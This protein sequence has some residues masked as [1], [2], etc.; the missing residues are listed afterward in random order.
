MSGFSFF[1][2]LVC[3]AI[4]LFF[5][6][7]QYSEWLAAHHG[8]I[9]LLVALF[10]MAA[11]CVL[12]FPGL[13]ILMFFVEGIK[14]IRHEGIKPSNLLSVLFSFLLYAYLAIWPRIGN[15]ADNTFG[16]MFY[17]I[18]SF[19]A[20]YLLSLMSVYSFSAVLNLVHLKKTGM[21]IIL[22][23][24]VQELSGPK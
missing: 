17:G 16:T 12:A 20:I 21:Q 4:F 2:M 19:S 18:V 9:L 22:L 13:M 23:Y 8:I 1:W 7:S 14:V 6:V 24:W 15:L 5:A 3:F 11:G 10:V